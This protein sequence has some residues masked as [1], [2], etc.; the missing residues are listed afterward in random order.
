MDRK[1]KGKKIGETFVEFWF[2]REQQYV[3]ME[4]F[5]DLFAYTTRLRWRSSQVVDFGKWVDL[6]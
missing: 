1:R 6:T 4:S 3:E 2:F 5:Q